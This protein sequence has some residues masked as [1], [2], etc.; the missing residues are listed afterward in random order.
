MRRYHW[1]RLYALLLMIL[2]F[3]TTGIVAARGFLVIYKV[4]ARQRRTV[5]S[6]QSIER[7]SSLIMHGITD[8][9]KTA[10]QQ[11]YDQ[12][13]ELATVEDDSRLSEDDLEY[14]FRI[15][16]VNKIKD[17][18]AQDGS[19]ICEKLDSFLEDDASVSVRYSPHTVLE[20][21]HDD[22]GETIGL[23]VKNVTIAYDDPH[24]GGRTD[25]ISYSIQFPEAVFHPGNDDL[26]RY[27]LVAG[28]GLYI[29]GRT[30]SVIGDLYAGVHSPEEVREAEIVYG[31]TGTYGGINVLTTQLGIRSDRIIC[32]GDININGSFVVFEP[33]GEKLDCYTQRINEMQGFSKS[34]QYSM[35]GDLHPIQAMEESDLMGFYDEIRAVDTALSALSDVPIYYD[36]DNDVGYAGKYRKLV[37]DKDIEI[38]NDFTGIAATPA[39]VIINK[40][41]NFEGILLCGNRIYMMGNNNI[42]ANP[43]VARSVI[44]SE[45]SGD[46]GFRIM[47]YIG[48]MKKPG[49]TDPEYYVIPRKTY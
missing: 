25:T 43:V 47:D 35:T 37:S 24:S 40:D 33:N 45:I 13:L 16:Y 36:S 48:G 19:G 18:F 10:G 6:V 7:A 31:E 39:N 3:A 2:L 34:A 46:Y 41:V 23:R 44:A 5:R 17:A 32:R 49:L 4:S 27:C 26:F 20:E 30:S 11:Q 21:E 42:V 8:I 9:A 28:K 29:T 15:G 12:L 38:R 1:V 14:Y 22:S